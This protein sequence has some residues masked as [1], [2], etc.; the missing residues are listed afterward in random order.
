MH[1]PQTN[2]SSWIEQMYKW[3]VNVTVL[4]QACEHYI[5]GAPLGGHC[6][7]PVLVVSL[8]LS[9]ALTCLMQR[10]TGTEQLLF[11]KRPLRGELVH[12]CEPC[13]LLLAFYFLL[14][15]AV[16]SSSLSHSDW[17]STRRLL[18]SAPLWVKAH[19]T[20]SCFCLC[21]LCCLELVFWNFF[22]HY[23]GLRRLVPVTHKHS[24]IDW[25][26]SWICV[27]EF[28]SFLLLISKKY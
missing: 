27:F 6:C 19:I 15:Y 12:V 10:T 28:M 26:M 9:S 18:L 17:S 21:H 22:R 16:L 23:A 25:A 11:H 1:G 5:V 8:S 20:L 14:S 3:A 13:L 4:I 7:Q 24:M 2:A